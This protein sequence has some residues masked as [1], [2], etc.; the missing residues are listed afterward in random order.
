MIKIL[1][2]TIAMGLMASLLLTA[3]TSTNNSLRHSNDSLGHS[4]DN[5]HAKKKNSYASKM[6]K[7]QKNKKIDLKK[8]CFKDNRSIHYN[9]KERCK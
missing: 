2:K 5:M 7:K 9:A 3:C 1:L 4:N 6:L 8:F